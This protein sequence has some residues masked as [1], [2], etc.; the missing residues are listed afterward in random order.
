MKAMIL[1]AGK[2]TRVWPITKTVPKPMISIFG[3]PLMESIIEHLK[4]FDVTDVVVNT[5][6]LAPVIE[7]YFRDGHQFGV[8]ISYSYEGKFEDGKLV[9]APIGSA[10]GMRKI[11]DFSGFFDETFVVLCGDALIDVDLGEVLK[12]H[13]ERKSIATIVTKPVPMDE[14]HKYGVVETDDT[15]RVLQFQ[16]KPSAEEAVSNCINTGIYIF[17]PEIFDHI[18]A[19]TVYDIGGELFP[20][21]AQKQVPFFAC[22]Q[23]FQ[24]VDVGSIKDVWT[25]AEMVMRGEVNNVHVPGRELQPGVHVGINTSIN[26]DKVKITGPVFIGNGT[27]I[28]D[29]VEITGPAIIGNNCH[30]E[31]HAT[32]KHSLVDDYT[33]VSSL[34]CIEDKVIFGGHS[35]N[36]EGEVT[37]IGQLDLGWLIGDSRFGQQ[38]PDEFQELIDTVKTSASL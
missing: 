31:Q 27:K 28:D 26:F 36:R 25:T 22:D 34:A 32:V 3:K 20:D 16:E 10:G 18:P 4:R 5:S 30:I 7:N 33:K 21:L 19:D 35:I 11:Q 15:G 37:E 13:K 1:G 29:N 38:A 6:Y 23:D 8:N 2:G 9:S 17:E 24:W 14:V 12:F